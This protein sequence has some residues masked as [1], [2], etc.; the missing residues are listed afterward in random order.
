MNIADF[1]SRISIEKREQKKNVSGY[2][3]GVTVVEIMKC[4]AKF[5]DFYSKELY[6]S[7]G[8]KLEGGL[9]VTVRYCKALSRLNDVEYKDKL[10]INFNDTIYK[11]QHIDFHNNNKVEITFKVVV[12]K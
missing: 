2:N 1:K 12:I 6:S 7:F 9:N 8:T 11:V 10:F 4:W 5:N 3:N